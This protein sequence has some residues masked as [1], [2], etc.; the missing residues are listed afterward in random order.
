MAEEPVPVV[1]LADGV[2][3]PVRLLGV[4]EDHAGFGPAMVVVAPH[5][6]VGP[7]VGAILPALLEPRVLV[8][9]VV[10]HHVGDDPHVAPVRLLDQLHH[11]AQRA[12]LGQHGEEVADVVA[13]VAQRRLVEGQEPDAVDAEPL[14]VVELVDEAPQVAGAVVVGVGET[15]DEH[16][17]E[18]G[19]LVPARIG[20]QVHGRCSYRSRKWNTCATCAT[21][22]SRTYWS[23]P[24][25]V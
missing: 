20:H 1:L 22:S 9:G 10:H 21:G 11:V 4:D 5:V 25:Q 6:P 7:W 16:L 14:Q 23:P 12:V 13:A 8:A 15:A 3:R 2:P 17:V 19:A 18:D 24:S